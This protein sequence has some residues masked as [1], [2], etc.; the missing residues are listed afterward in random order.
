MKKF[1]LI[2]G[3]ALLYRGFFAIPPHLTTSKGE[4]VNAVFGVASMLLNL[5]LKEKPDFLAV[6]FDHK[7]KTFRHKEFEHY[8]ATRPAAPEGLH[9]QLPILKE[10]FHAFKIPIFEKPGFEA[11]DILATL[12]DKALHHKDIRVLIATGDMDVLQL[13]EK[14]VS[15]LAPQKGFN[16]TKI[17][18]EAA[19]KEK[20]ELSPDQMIDYKAL[21]GDSS[22]NVPGVHGIG[23]KTA[24]KLL[25]E[26]K[27]LENIYENLNKILGSV[28]EKLTK[29]KEMGFFSKKLV[30]LVHDVPLDF[31]LKH[32]EVCIDWQKV[33]KIFEK[34][35]FSSLIKK[36]KQ[37]SKLPDEKQATLF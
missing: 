35:E 15:I 13:V 8:K 22:D 18:D 24:I 11:D 5:Y 9:E 14:R 4:M 28:K 10:V 33:L 2:D 29:N 37:I 25:K 36:I 32:C 20:Y 3:T 34:L 30:T 21:R 7:E 23:E 19:I 26:Y 6:T 1:I 17:Y 31:N 27:T 16:E 12:T